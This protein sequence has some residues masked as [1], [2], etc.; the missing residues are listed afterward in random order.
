MVKFINWH[1]K[2]ERFAPD[3]RIGVV[4]NGGFQ[5]GPARNSGRGKNAIFDRFPVP[6]DDDDG[7][8]DV[9][10][11]GFPSAL[12][13]S[14]LDGQ[15]KVIPDPDK[16]EKKL[17]GFSFFFLM[18]AD[19]TTIKDGSHV[20]CLYKCEDSSKLQVRKV[21]FYVWRWFYWN[22]LDN[23]TKDQQKN[24]CTCTFLIE[25]EVLTIEKLENALRL[26]CTK[27]TV[28]SGLAMK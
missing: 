5:P 15:V 12:K 20:L 1:F 14:L 19:E 6:I 23:N 17:L 28:N 22:L 18:E 10:R 8:F 24:H 21:C 2:A 26:S 27:T 7:D 13:I 11:R 16:N 3:R 4:E 25:S 9:P